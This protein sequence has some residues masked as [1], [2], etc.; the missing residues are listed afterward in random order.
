M[1]YFSSDFKLGIIGGGQLGKM[2]LQ[3][4]S[5]L[6]IK[7]NILD[8]NPDSPCKNLCNE[9][10]LGKLMDYDTIYKFGKKCNVI[11]YE[12]EHINIEA[13]LKLESEG[14]I[15]N[16]SP[17]I[18]KIIQN[19]N[20]QKKFF[21]ENNIPTAKFWHF[22]SKEEFKLFLSNDEIS[23]PCVWKKTKFGYDGFG[24][25]I[26]KSTKDIT[27]LP[28]SEFII[29]EYIPF[30]KELA[31]TIARNDSGQVEVFP[32][33]EMS[34]NDES[35]QVEYVI[36]P[37]QINN[38]NMIRAK[39]IALSVSKSFGHTGILAVE[40]FLTKDN[41]VLVNEVAPRPHNSAHYSIE[42]CMSS[43]FDQHIRSI[44]NLPLGCSK[45]NI[46]A[47]MVNL[48]G[49]KNFSGLVNYEGVEESMK[50]DNVSV[51]IYGKS[52]TRPNRKMGHATILDTDLNRGIEIAKSVKKNIRVKTN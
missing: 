29:E 26:L 40:M 34:F 47:I 20:T 27:K 8:S 23:F 30:Q 43:Q 15:I 9:F 21:L 3:V 38:K 13:L 37:A 14:V 45:S 36:C 44:L 11:T 28:D 16:P 32:I 25:E 48:V 2:L 12:I 50:F 5:K 17:S 31:T 41:K 51:H 24:V 10:S 18:L 22:R 1:D 35:N 7:T 39:E 19:K 4:T 46:N 33:V 42:A 52:E 6:N 49:E